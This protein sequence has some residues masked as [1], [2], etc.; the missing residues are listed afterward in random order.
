MKILHNA[1]W[2]GRTGRKGVRVENMKPILA[3]IACLVFVP[4]LGS[5]G[6]WTHQAE[7][8]EDATSAHYY[9]FET[10]GDAIRRVRWVWNGGAQN[11]PMVTD[12]LFGPG[13]ITVRHM[14][15]KRKD[16]AKLVAGRPADLE[17]KQE[18]SIPVGSTSGTLAP[19]SLP[20]SLS[21]AQRNDLNNLI[22]LLAMERRPCKA[23]VRRRVP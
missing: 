23:K 1:E 2:L 18:Y 4:A 21:K 22:E 5:A 14:V 3:A 19:S 10:S 6:E 13:K 7:E 12:Y 16:A 17:V 15:G 11:P 20:K 9:F 8:G